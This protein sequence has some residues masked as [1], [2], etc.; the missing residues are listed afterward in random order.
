MHPGKIV[1]ILTWAFCL[2]CFFVA[3]ESAIAGVGRMV[4]WGMAAIHVVEF[5]IFLPAI[6]RA[7][8]AIP[9]HFARILAFGV[10]HLQEI[11]AFSK[12]SSKASP[13]PAKR[14]RVSEASPGPAQRDRADPSA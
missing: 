3:S 4:F 5:A 2:G 7:G 12:P 13:G 9:G 6:R 1:L 8:G 11:G 14:N 10:L